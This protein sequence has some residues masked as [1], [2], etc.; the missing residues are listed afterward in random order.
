[1]WG[2]SVLQQLG[3]V[4]VAIDGK[5]VANADDLQNALQ[6]K[7]PGQSVPIT[8]IRDGSQTTISVRLSERPPQER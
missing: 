3:D 5:K 8:L 2:N 4:I 1:M 7:Q 6:D